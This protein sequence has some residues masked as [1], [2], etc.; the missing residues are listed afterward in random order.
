MH[1]HAI[2]A[3]HTT[4]L[5]RHAITA[6]HVAISY[7]AVA[8]DVSVDSMLATLPV[9]HVPVPI[10]LGFIYY[11]LLRP[12]KFLWYIVPVVRVT[13]CVV[14]NLFKLSGCWSVVR[15]LLQAGFKRAIQ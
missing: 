11:G 14:G 1:G 4:A 7:R 8:A 5:S 13:Q 3:T 9:V 2:A 6:A 12:V 15:I 10:W